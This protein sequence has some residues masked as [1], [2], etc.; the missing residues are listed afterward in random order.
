[1]ESRITYQTEPHGRIKPFTEFIFIPTFFTNPSRKCF[2]TN[3]DGSVVCWLFHHDFMWAAKPHEPS[4]FVFFLPSIFQ[5]SAITDM[6]AVHSE[7]SE[8]YYLETFHVLYN[9]DHG[10]VFIPVQNAYHIPQLFQSNALYG[11]PSFHSLY[12]PVIANAIA[13]YAYPAST[14]PV[15]GRVELCG[16]NLENRENSKLKGNVLEE[17]YRRPGLRLVF[18]EDFRYNEST[19]RQALHLEE[20]ATLCLQEDRFHCTYFEY[21][22]SLCFFVENP[23]WK[24]RDG[25]K[26]LFVPSPQIDYYIRLTDDVTNCQGTSRICPNMQ[27]CGARCDLG[28]VESGQLCYK[29]FWFDHDISWNNASHECI[30]RNASLASIR[31]SSEARLIHSMASEYPLRMIYIGLTDVTDEGTYLWTNDR[32]VTYTDWNLDRSVKELNQS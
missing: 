4:T 25:K 14:H 27:R 11:R 24:Y 19:E 9:R 12:L 2:I 17:F 28:W 26:N 21:G 5:I 30:D 31:S 23:P 32:P 15:G 7:S 22:G 18:H 10:E 1:M 16:F 8:K 20:C 13:V 6:I 3:A 29:L